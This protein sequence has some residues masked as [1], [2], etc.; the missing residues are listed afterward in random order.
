MDNIYCF[1]I[2]F[3]IV[4]QQ[5]FSLKTVANTMLSFHFWLENKRHK[6]I[7]AKARG[8]RYSDHAWPWKNISGYPLAVNQ[9]RRKRK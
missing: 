2:A 5:T 6:N 8:T 3:V 9:E 7:Q 4:Y 1:F